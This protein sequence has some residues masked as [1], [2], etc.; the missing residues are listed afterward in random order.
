MALKFIATTGRLEEQGVDA[1]IVAAWEKELTRDAKRVDELLNGEIAQAIKRKEFEGKLGSL[2]V[3]RTL[4]KL[5]QRKVVVVGLGKRKEFGENPRHALEASANSF[6]V[7]KNYVESMA[8]K[9]S[10]EDAASVVEASV[11]SSYDFQEFKTS[12]E[13][14]KEVKAKRVVL[15]F[16]SAS[17]AKGAEKRIALAKTI[18]E[19]QNQARMLD[20]TNPAVA[21]PKYIAEHARKLAGGKLKVTVMSA[22]ELKKK[23]Y[24]GILSVG[25]GSVPTCLSLN[26]I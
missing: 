24:N 12:S 7:I 2:M 26:D 15:V 14:K 22:K 17:E 25:K 18:A 10:P 5:K 3:L 11:L 13:D 16:N 6:G 8:F 4:G 9:V 1:I 23:G 19:A 21:T 20:N